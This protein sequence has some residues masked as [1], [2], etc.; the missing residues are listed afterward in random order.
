MNKLKDFHPEHNPA[1]DISL[2]TFRSQGDIDETAIRGVL[3]ARAC[4][5]DN[6]QEFMRTGAED[7]IWLIGLVLDGLQALP[8]SQLVR[9]FRNLH[10]N[11]L[12]FNNISMKGIVINNDEV[13]MRN[14][15][16]LSELHSALSTAVLVFG[17]GSGAAKGNDLWEP[18]ANAE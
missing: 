14:S 16:F 8:K 7:R 18:L 4:T 5:I 1:F 11:E 12:K 17:K 9:F 3:A 2:E 13:A 10:R 15:K 6:F